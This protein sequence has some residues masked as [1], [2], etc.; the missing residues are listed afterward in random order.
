M[1]ETLFATVMA[2]AEIVDEDQ[3]FA[4]KRLNFGLPSRDLLSADPLCLPFAML[5]DVWDAA[6]TK[7]SNYRFTPKDYEPWQTIKHESPDRRADIVGLIGL[8]FIRD[9]FY[10]E[11]MEVGKVTLAETRL[12]TDLLKSK[13][14]LTELHVLALIESCRSVHDMDWGAP[15]KP[16]LKSIDRFLADNIPSAVLYD[17]LVAFKAHCADESDRLASKLLRQTTEQ[18]TG[19]IAENR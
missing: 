5:S 2:E 14:P 15:L 12:I 18:L 11:S 13:L 7:R 4:N 9:T 16:V 8:R 1:S 3:L 19:L 6:I 10:R 17:T